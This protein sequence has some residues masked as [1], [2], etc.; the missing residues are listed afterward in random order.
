MRPRLPALLKH[1]NSRGTPRLALFVAAVLTVPALLVGPAAAEPGGV[2]PAAI[3]ADAPTASTATAPS[4]AES[5]AVSPAV[6]ATTLATSASTPNRA[7][8]ATPSAPTAALA[9]EPSR[10]SSK[11]IT[12]DRQFTRSFCG[13]TLALG[14]IEKCG[15]IIG[16]AKDTWTF[17]TPAGSDTLY[18][19]FRQVAGDSLSAAIHDEDGAKLCDLGANLNTC[20]TFRGG[21]HTVTVTTAAGAG[22]GAYTL[23]VES[24]RNP[25]ACEQ[26][27]EHVFSW[28]SAGISGS[29]PAGLAAR[30]FTFDQPVGTVLFIADPHS[31]HT[32]KHRVTIVD[33]QNWEFCAT[34]WSDANCTLSKAGP[35]RVFLEEQAGV[36]A[37]YTIR[38]PR[39]SQAVGCAAL[40]LAPFGDPGAAIGQGTLQPNRRACHAFTTTTAGRVE[41]RVHGL[42]A[43]ASWK[44]YDNAGTY[45]CDQSSVQYCA[46]PTA[47]QYTV[48]LWGGNDSR[49][50]AYQL[51]VTALHRNDGCASTTGTSWDQPTLVVHQTSPVQTNCHPFE[52][53]AG[54]RMVVYAAHDSSAWLFDQS[55]IRVCDTPQPRSGAYGCVLPADGTYRVISYL[56]TSAWQAGATYP[57]Q[58]RRLSDAA[59]CPTL[60]PGGYDVP[61]VLSG[62]RCRTLEIT[63]AGDFRLRTVSA[64]ND[65]VL[66]WVHDREGQQICTPGR[67]TFPAAGR[68]TLVFDPL[69][70]VEPDVEHAAVLAPWAPSGCPTVS[71]TGWRDAPH[72][73][74]FQVAGQLNCLQLSSPAGAYVVLSQPKEPTE[75]PTETIVVD[76]TGNQACRQAADCLLSGQ[77]P[78]FLLYNG[79]INKPTGTYG[80]AFTRLDGP[81]ACP[82]LPLDADTT[83]TTGPNRFVACYS[84]P[85]DQRAAREGLTWKRTTGTGVAG[86]EIFGSQGFNYSCSQYGAEGNLRCNPPAGPLTVLV[87]TDGK[88]A[89]YRLTRWDASTPTS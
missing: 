60:V 65:A 81:P 14:T 53:R 54:D 70:V 52:G 6:S 58:I 2:T 30:C 33:T 24:R 22:K 82:V 88:D 64:D 83:V 1:G 44:L 36:G 43:F 26:L 23:S 50:R 67:C 77:A 71:D 78:F 27:P 84:I 66:S 55:G 79:V 45:I 29:L 40:P 47:G 89:T 49:E 9:T 4:A 18:V 35:Y 32:S 56:P 68:Y 39:I 85:A 10:T 3:T 41:V 37:A 73:G 11:A 75:R 19:Q 28:A 13:G 57:I 25:S 42:S 74:A 16:Q 8:A 86:V 80:L 21:T 48:L 17:T 62:I 87:E 38:L 69:R 61:P 5:P 15:L 63:E 31:R 34:H 76:S 51:T 72:R 12:R 20:R 46:L 7:T 59:G